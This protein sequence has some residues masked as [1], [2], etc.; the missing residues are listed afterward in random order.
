MN[1]FYLQ[2]TKF[3]KLCPFLNPPAKLIYLQIKGIS[4]VKR[5]KP[6]I[7]TI[8]LIPN[9]PPFRQG[10]SLDYEWVSILD[11]VLF[12]APHRSFQQRT[13]NDGYHISPKRPWPR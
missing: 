9:Y 1:R 4:P 10:K 5:P 12:K 3:S 2:I 7:L 11:V 6:T 8:L 13:R